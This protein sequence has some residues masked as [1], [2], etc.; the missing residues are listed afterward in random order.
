ME[1]LTG[2]QLGPYQIT[3]PL[4]E[5]GMAAVYQAYQPAMDR[6]VALKILPRHFA[7]D[8]QFTSRFQQEAKLLAKLQHPRILPVFDFGTADGYAYIV[9]P[10]VEGG[11]LVDRMRGRPLPLEQIRR[12]IAQVGDA[13]DYA[14]LCG[15]VH[16]DVKPS[17]ILMDERENCLLTDFGLAKIVEGTA[18]LT[19]SGAIMGTPAYMSPEQ[20]LGQ[21]LDARSDIYSLGVVLYEMAT[22][23]VPYSAETPMAVVIKHIH[24]PLPPPHTLNPSLPEAL[25]RVILKSLA[26]T[27]DDRF[28]TA[29]E[30]VTALE[31]AIPEGIPVP[32]PAVPKPKSS[33]SPKTPAAAHRPLAGT[34][35]LWQPVA[36]T[37][38]GWVFGVITGLIL[39]SLNPIL[40]VALAGAIGGLGIGLAWRLIEP[41]VS[42]R[43]LLN[44]IVIWTPAI[45]LAVVSGPLFF[46]IGGLAGWLTGLVLRQAQPALN[47]RR[48]A[49]IALGWS[50]GWLVGGLLFIIATTALVELLSALLAIVAVLLA[51]ALGGAVMFSQYRQALREAGPPAT[52]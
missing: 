45:G 3:A 44:L 22:G 1:D 17:N 41:A 6:S 12:A 48:R 28:A 30:M 38:A 11:T 13:L 20:G 31:R 27:P 39:A 40:G 14:H 42:R 47:R 2:R 34:R 23:R 18:H 10:L 51:G 25:V 4:G 50:A 49:F 36:V 26:K 43:Q 5:G 9:M 24:D 15:L 29:G 46:A 8:P 37:I 32:P 7:A 33:A 35:P 52:G 19:T 16:R 21:K